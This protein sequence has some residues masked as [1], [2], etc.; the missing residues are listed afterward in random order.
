MRMIGDIQDTVLLNNG[1]RMPGF[2]LGCFD[3]TGSAIEDAV[4]W[5]AEAGYRMFDT[6]A[7]Y[8]NE[9]DVGRGIRECGV[10]RERLFVVSKMWQ[11]AF[12]RPEEAVERS[13][14]ELDVGC[15]DAYLLHWPGTDR[16]KRY[17]AWE[18]VL[19]AV[20]KGLVR[21][22]GV[23]NFQREH[24]EDLIS[25]FGVAP[26][27][28]QIEL[29]PWYQ[30]RELVKY[31]RRLGI[32]VEGWGPIFHGHMAEAAPQFT[33]L[34]EKY[35]RSPV[36]IVLRWHIQKEH[37]LIPKSARKERI[38]ENAAIFDF[39]LDGEDMRSIDALECGRCFGSD[40]YA[41]G[42]EDWALPSQ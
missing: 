32:A 37:M 33:K 9:R 3:G 24:L 15:I 6:A 29:H 21:C 40:P 26:A 28:N 14:R 38:A 17:R 34:A 18:A 7:R 35:G 20:E 41:Y 2:G 39:S 19:N 8:E 1:V 4:V 16:E 25:R 27:V 11:T 31:C 5:A 12:G 23:S 36:Q 13:L 10:P 30:E 22:A 42:G